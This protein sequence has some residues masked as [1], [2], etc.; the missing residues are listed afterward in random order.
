MYRL[1][2][3]DYKKSKNNIADK[4]KTMFEVTEKASQMLN[5]FLKDKGE[6]HTIRVMMMEGG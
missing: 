6:V 2:P 5:E 1:K 3:L 4:E